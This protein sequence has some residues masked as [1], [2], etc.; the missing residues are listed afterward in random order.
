MAPRMTFDTLSPDFPKLVEYAYQPIVLLVLERGID[1]LYFV[2]C[3][4]DLLSG[5]IIKFIYAE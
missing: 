1:R 2:Y 3:I 5:A 4:L